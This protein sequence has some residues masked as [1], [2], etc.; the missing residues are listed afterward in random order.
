MDVLRLALALLAPV[1]P[2][3]P[4]DPIAG[5][6]GA[7]ERARVVAIG[8]SHGHEELHQL[9]IRLLEDPRAQGLIDDLAVEWGNGLYQDVIDRYLD[10]ASVPWDS[11]T[12]AWRNTVVSPGLVW[13]GPVYQR[14]FEAVRR[15]NAELPSDRRYRVILADS[16]VD[17][18]RVASR[19]DLGPFAD[20]GLAMADNV[21]RLSLLEGRRALFLA[22]GLHVHRQPRTFPTR[23]GIPRG[24]IPPVAWIELRHPGTVYVIQSMARAVDLEIEALIG[25]G[26]P[27]FVTMA[28][29][30][31]LA[32]LDAD[33]IHTLRNADGT[34]PRVYRD[35]RFGDLV[36][37]VILWDRS[38]LHYPE[39]DPAIYRVDWYWQ[40]LERR[41]RLL[42]GRPMD[43]S[44]RQPSGD[45]P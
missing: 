3:G 12:M 24:E 6:L 30:P 27:R 17:W 42:R 11:V 37:A 39:P 13:D 31:T 20:R 32:A 28:E 19:N 45:G 16:P 34:K 2:T 5:I 18:S 26:P 41:S 22:G 14:F 23:D 9:V 35:L 36:D 21:R 15:I 38:A 4:G 29:S 10:G 1:A 7:F 44:L 33:R 43:P 40:E 8:E 25:S